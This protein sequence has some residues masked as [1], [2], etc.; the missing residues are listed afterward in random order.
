MSKFIDIKAVAEL[1]GVSR[2]TIRKLSKV[3]Q[4]PKPIRIGAS[5][6]WD[7]ADVE[8]FIAEKKSEAA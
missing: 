2:D 6:R 5:V 1:A 8:K 4:F 3:G 7:E